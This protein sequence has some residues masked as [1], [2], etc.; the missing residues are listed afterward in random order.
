MLRYVANVS[1]LAKGNATNGLRAFYKTTWT[2]C[3]GSGVDIIAMIPIQMFML[4]YVVACILFCTAAPT[5]GY[6]KNSVEEF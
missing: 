3:S 4:F 1:L 2:A 5:S 6:F